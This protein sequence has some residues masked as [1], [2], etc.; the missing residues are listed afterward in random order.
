[1]ISVIV[2]THNRSERLKKCIDSILKQSFIDWEAIIVDDGSTDNTESVVK[3]YTDPR[4]IYIKRKENYGCDTLPKNQGVMASTGKYIS[5]LDDDVTF[6][7]DH[8]QVLFNELERN[9]KVDIV[10]GDRWLV[11]ET[12]QMPDQLGISHDFDP[13]FLMQ[14]NYIDTSDVL[15]RRQAFFDV[16]GFD[17]RF[18]KYIDWNLWVRMAKD[19]KKFKHIPMIITDYHLHNSMKSVLIKDHVSVG[20]KNVDFASVAGSEKQKDYRPELP[21]NYPQFVP[22]WDPYDVEV[23]LPF[24]GEKIHEPKVAVFSLTYDR[25]EYTKKSFDSLFKTA[26]YKFDLF[27]VDNGSTDGTV[28]Y[29]NQLF[30]EGKIKRLKLN[31][32]NEGISRASNEAIRMIR[33]CHDYEIVVKSDN[34]CFYLTNGWLAKMVDIW[35][36]N[37]IFALSCYVQGL[38]DNPGGSP[39]VGYGTIKGEFIGI[40]KHLGGINHFADIRGYDDFEWD[41]S[42]FLHGSQDM[43]MSQN[44]FYKGWTM[45]YMENYFV[46]HGPNTE[47]QKKDYKDYFERRKKEKTKRYEETAT[48]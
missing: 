3:S 17:E 27:V 42:D 25:L 2:S 11:D 23:K 21:T 35:T 5:L 32:K 47:Q 24:L 26:G 43:E 1:M 29:L 9:K 45:G 30:K 7:V 8:L 14:R 40:A 18:K 33:C 15:I 12:K 4:I 10:Y 34:D 44:L 20:P 48:K 36:S 39:R 19:G 37:K 38:V 28:E 16:G 22:E 13:D 6:R 46:S 31:E 41:Q